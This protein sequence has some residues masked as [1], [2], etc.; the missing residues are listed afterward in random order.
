MGIFTSLYIPVTLAPGSGLCRL[1]SMAESTLP[2]RVTHLAWH[3]IQEHSAR[4]FW[5]QP[6]CRLHAMFMCNQTKVNGRI[7]HCN[8]TKQ[9]FIILAPSG[10]IDAISTHHM[11]ALTVNFPSAMRHAAPS[12]CVLQL[13]RIEVTLCQ[14]LQAIKCILEGHWQKDISIHSQKY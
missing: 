9:S 14:L 12:H 10:F 1:P 13:Q 4:D 5:K 6:L 7:L 8:T 2:S 11:T 3:R